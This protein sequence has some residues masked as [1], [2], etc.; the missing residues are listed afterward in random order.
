MPSPIKPKLSEEQKDEICHLFAHGALKADLARKFD[1][2]DSTIGRVIKDRKVQRIPPP[3]PKIAS[4][5][6]VKEFA[7]KAKSILW[8]SEGGKNQAAF[9]AWKEK[10]EYLQS[11]VGGSLSE[12]EAVVKASREFRCL[13]TLFREFD[14]TEFETRPDFGSTSSGATEQLSGDFSRPPASRMKVLEQK[15]SYREALRWA[16]AAA[17]T[18]LATGQEPY[19]C[20]N[21]IA[22]FLYRQG[23]DEPKDFMAKVSQMEMKVD[24]EEERRQ[25]A[26]SAAKVEIA[27]IREFLEELDAH[28]ERKVEENDDD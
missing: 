6:N 23:I 16:M 27:D 11:V 20:P 8:R 13:H 10:V 17:G 4:G 7:K 12:P 22:F 3:T 24:V 21:Y 14:V 5:S 28:E 18:F 9:D 25:N 19:E 15:T 2:H 1:V 26:R